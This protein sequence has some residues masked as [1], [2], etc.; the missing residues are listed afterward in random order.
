M[1]PLASNEADRLAALRALGIV[2]TPEEAHFEAVCRLARDV[3][4]VPIALISFIEEDRQWFK[5]KCGLSVDGTSRDVAFCTYAILAD[6]VMVVEDATT[7]PRFADNPLVQGECGVRFYAGAPLVLRPG[8]H[9]GTLCIKDTVPRSLSAEQVRQL[10]DLAEIVVAH[11]RLHEANN[12]LKQEIVAREEHQNFILSQAQEIGRREAALREANRLLLMA[13]QMAHAG[14]WRLELPDQHRVWSD[15]VYRIFG[16]DP[17]MGMPSLTDAINGYHADDQKRVRDTLANA[18][19]MKA[20]FCFKARIVRP[21]SELRD[22]VVRGT[23]DAAR[24]N[25]RGALMGVIID[26]TEFNRAQTRLREA[27]QR[28]R[29]AIEGMADYAII[30]LDPNGCVSSWNVGA[31]HIIGYTADEIVG[32]HF[33]RFYTTED[34]ASCVPEHAL[35]TA[36]RTGHFEAESWRVWV[37]SSDEV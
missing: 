18:A 26:I 20:D 6:D 24:A 13:E 19:V 32:Q 33:S 11:L 22:V 10:R 3:F 5:A 8:I 37:A 23:Y 12:R 27:E 16:L 31:Q 29:L 15:E 36:A 1:F 9:V 34:Q 25:N 28:F 30:M 14:H 21:S 4:A 7:D 35:Q 2:N 17:Q